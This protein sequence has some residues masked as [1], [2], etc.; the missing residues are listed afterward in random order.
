MAIQFAGPNGKFNPQR[1]AEVIRQFGFTEARYFAEQR[2]TMLRREI[3]TTVTGGIEP[4]QIL[5]DVKNRFDN[6]TRTVN[7][8]NGRITLGEV[9]GRIEPAR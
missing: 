2:R 9:A 3:G 6:E 7:Y 5:L 1:F 4:P 8:L